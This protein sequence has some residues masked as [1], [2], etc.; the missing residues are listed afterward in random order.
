MNLALSEVLDLVRRWQNASA[1]IR[2]LVQIASGEIVVEFDG[3]AIV[4]TESGI[5]ITND[6]GEECRIALQQTMTFTY[7]DRLLR[8]DGAGWRCNLWET[9]DK[10]LIRL[11]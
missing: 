8:I 3:R 9:K 5:T 11:V 7:A 6:I 1:E 10:N 4:E 2:V